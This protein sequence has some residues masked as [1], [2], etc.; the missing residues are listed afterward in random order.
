M[1]AVLLLLWAGLAIHPET[2]DAFVTAG[3]F[4][5]LTA[6]VAEIVIIGVGMTL[7]IL[8]GGIDLSVGATMALAGVIAA[9]LQIDHRQPA[10]LACAAAVAAAGLVGLWHGLLV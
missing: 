3:N 2:R 4:S 6:Q 9:K 1:V 10:Y 5:N 7:V 8:I